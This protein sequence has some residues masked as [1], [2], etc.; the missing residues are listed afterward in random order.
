MAT[1]QTVEQPLE[2]LE[3]L[4]ELDEPEEI[5]SF[6]LMRPHLVDL[7]LEAKEPID[8]FFGM[9]A[10]VKLE[11]LFDP[12]SSSPESDMLFG[13]IHSSLDLDAAKHALQAFTEQWWLDELP[14]ADGALGFDIAFP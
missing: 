3:R 14:R 9:T 4:F 7:L 10:T 5:R 8:R 11:V 2:H 13:I 1:R 12:E 6:L